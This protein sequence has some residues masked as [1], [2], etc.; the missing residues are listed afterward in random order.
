MST[1]TDLETKIISLNDQLKA[2][3]ES[4]YKA[5]CEE[6]T[7]HPGDV[8]T[9]SGAEYQVERLWFCGKD[10]KNPWVYGRRK[11]KG[12]KFGERVTCLYGNW[13]RR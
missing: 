13:S 12:G 8:V 7:V 6:S 5:Q 2:A 3:K 11:T 4:L 9:C 1:V 10:T